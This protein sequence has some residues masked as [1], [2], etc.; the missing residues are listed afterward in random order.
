VLSGTSDRLVVASESRDYVTPTYPSRPVRLSVFDLRR[1][2]WSRLPDSRWTPVA[3]PDGV[4]GVGAV[5]N[6][7]REEGETSCRV[8]VSTLRWS[9]RRWRHRWVGRRAHVDLVS[10]CIWPLGV[11]G[12]RAYLTV[13]HGRSAKVLG[14]RA[15]GD[16]RTLPVHPGADPLRPENGQYFSTSLRCISSR[17]IDVLQSTSGRTA[18]GETEFTGPMRH[19]TDRSARPRWSVARRAPVPLPGIGVFVCG[20]RGVVMLHSP[21]TSEWDGRRF[22]TTVASGTPTQTPRYTMPAGCCTPLAD[23]GFAWDDG[24][25]VFRLRGRGWETH[26]GAASATEIVRDR[27]AVGNLVVYAVL[28]WAVDGQSMSLRVIP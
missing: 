21:G 8:Q 16:V 24:Y 23:G 2:R 3:L 6:R 18:A 25:K 27:T 28:D 20:P 7:V 15:D 10:C 17:G 26:E 14:V 4:V 12:D 13:P 22:V 9:Q 19:L 5:C 11:R 1:W